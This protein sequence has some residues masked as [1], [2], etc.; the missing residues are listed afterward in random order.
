MVFVGSPGCLQIHTGPVQAL[1]ATPPWYNVLDPDF[2]LHLNEERIDP[3]WVVQKPTTDGRVTSLEL[4]DENGDIIARLFGERKS[5][6]PERDDWRSILEALPS[7][8]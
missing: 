8:S 6:Q 4:M 3:A 5:G 2:Q 1:K 7:Q